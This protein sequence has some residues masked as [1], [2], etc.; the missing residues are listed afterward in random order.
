MKSELKILLLEDIAEEAVLIERAIRRERLPSVIKR[1]D[2]KGEFES[3]LAIFQPDVVLSDH[4][5]PQFNSIEA[6]NLCRKH[7]AA[8]PFILVTGTVSEE[9]AVTCLKQG[10]DDYVLKSN[11]SRLP[12]AIMNSLN[13]REAEEQKKMAENE[14]RV[15]YEQVRKS[16]L[17]LTKINKELDSFVY[18]VSHNLRE[19]LSSILGIINVARL[20]H[21]I[22]DPQYFNMIED[23]IHRLDQT[24]KDILDYSMNNRSE[25]RLEALDLKQLFFENFER[26]KYMPA[27]ASMEVAFDG[28]AHTAC[29]SDRYRIEL[30][31]HNLISNAIKFHDHSKEK[32][33]IHLSVTTQD[34]LTI[35]FSD[36][37]LGIKREYLP[38]I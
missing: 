14:L 35:I 2:T 37:G 7:N 24:L 34:V 26:L 32:R 15:Q 17:E 13:Q 12:A 11:L 33:Y 6:L 36:N 8:I 20:E 27:A 23:S 18:S 30:I 28:P 3:A 19:P 29:Y 25:I 38:K 21:K 31:L 10:A 9:F 4:M 5:L 16:N 22:T 1:V